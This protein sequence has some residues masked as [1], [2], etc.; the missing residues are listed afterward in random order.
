MSQLDSDSGMSAGNFQT[1]KRNSYSIIFEP[2]PEFQD[3]PEFTFIQSNPTVV[4]RNTYIHS[5]YASRLT[6][7]II[8]SAINAF[9]FL[10]TKEDNYC[11]K[12]LSKVNKKQKNATES[13][14][15]QNFLNANE[16]NIYGSDSILNSYNK[17]FQIP[18]QKNC[19]SNVN[20][21]EDIYD[22]PNTEYD[23][24][25]K[26]H[27]DTILCKKRI[28]RSLEKKKNHID[29]FYYN[30]EEFR[31]KSF[32]YNNQNYNVASSDNYN[33]DKFQCNSFQKKFDKFIQNKFN[34]SGT[35]TI[36]SRLSSS[37]NSLVTASTNKAD[38]SIFI[39]QAMSHDQLGQNLEIS[40]FYNVPIDSECPY[41]LPIDVIN[42]NH[43]A[44]HMH[45]I[46]SLED[47]PEI[48]DNNLL[49]AN[50][51]KDQKNF[52]GKDKRSR[53]KKRSTK[54]L[55]MNDIQK[56]Q[57]PNENSPKLLTQN[58]HKVRKDRE[59]S[60]CDGKVQISFLHTKKCEMNVATEMQESSKK[61][62]QLSRTLNL[63]QKFYNM[64]NSFKK[65][66]Q[67]SSKNRSENLPISSE[68]KEEK[69]NR[70]STRALPPL[71]QGKILTFL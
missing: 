47:H 25:Y 37:H 70:L 49:T 71:P 16:Q 50:E 15:F 60:K 29:L 23:F 12:H 20:L 67:A 2:P 53:K 54:F 24:I 42:N 41:T 30:T 33:R 21:P 38:D 44:E 9:R 4:R 26:D 66:N 18:Y 1:I 52:R 35:T 7:N 14:N 19:N 36:N 40:D 65:S 6:Q 56:Y 59:R 31:L 46:T 55:D 5:T 51:T 13:E 64:F 10:V 8:N 22:E 3:Y 32:S 27:K 17:P 57:N 58:D 48:S 63:K 69:K 45:Q 68:V 34:V 61:N 39:T 43:K 11:R 28:V 62:C